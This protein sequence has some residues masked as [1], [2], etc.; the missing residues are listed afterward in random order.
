MKSRRDALKTLAPRS[1]THAGLWLDR[2]V[3]DLAR[4][5]EG[6]V[7]L[8]IEEVLSR[9]RVPDDYRLH[10]KRWRKHVE[11][12]PPKTLTAEARVDGR[13]IVGLGVESAL[14]I[15]I[16]LHRVYGVPY[17]PGAALKGL[18]SATADRHVGGA[19]A[20][21]GTGRSTGA[22]GAPAP[23][24][25]AGDSHRV[26]FGDTTV[27]GYVT[28][29]DALWIP[30]RE[31]ELPLDRDVMTVHHA[32]YYGGKDEPPAEWDNPNPVAF[33]TARGRYLLAVT[34]PERWADAAMSLLKLGLARDGIGAKTAAGYGRMTVEYEP[35]AEREAKEARLA[36]ERKAQEER[37]RQARERDVKMRLDRLT[38]QNAA[39]EVPRLLSAVTPGDR[40]I[41]AEAILKRIEKKWLKDRADQPWAKDLLAAL[42]R[43]ID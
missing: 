33:V 19:W 15:S 8:H 17:I 20:R 23:A 37:E 16:T 39:T 42:G 11:D 34:G 13:M 4:K 35:L 26:V 3:P 5:S 32:G 25:D 29:H 1:S 21:A 18:A 41:V 43:S 6:A 40:R 22:Q 12:L 24:R 27:A 10:F 30:E 28:F 36:A 31:T 38:K 2:F 7:A 14:E 9:I